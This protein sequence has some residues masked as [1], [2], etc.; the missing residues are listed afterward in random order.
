MLSEKALI[1]A[2]LALSPSLRFYTSSNPDVDD[3]AEAK[4]H[5]MSV[6]R[7]VVKAYL[8]ALAEEG[9]VIE[10]GWR[11]IETAPRD[12]SDVLLYCPDDGLNNEVCEGHFRASDYDG[13]ERW[14]ASLGNDVLQPSKW[15]P[16]PGPPAMISKA[17]Q[18]E[19]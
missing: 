19:G 11:P 2:G 16:L 6:T 5:C 12:F 1:V 17:E 9:Y 7:R 4:D 13:D 18:G 10:Q 8:T 3:I 14:H 15:R